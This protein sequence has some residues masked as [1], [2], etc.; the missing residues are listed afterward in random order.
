MNYLFNKQR[1]LVEKPS[2]NTMIILFFAL[3]FAGCVK[4]DE[5]ISPQEGTIY[6]PQAYQDRAT[7]TVYKIDS[8]QSITFGATYSGFKSAPSDITVE[9]QVDTSLIAAYNALN[10]YLGYTYYA[11]P[12]SA[13]T[14]SATKAVIP[15]GKTSSEPLEI[16]IQG[17]K[18]SFGKHY[19]L[20]IKLVNTASAK[21]DSSLS[22]AYFKLDTLLTRSRDLTSLGTLTVSDE[23]SGGADAG[24]GS[25]KL[26]DNDY[27]TKF[28]SFDYNP[29]FWVQLHLSSAEKLN[30][31]IITSGNDAPERDP[32]DWQF[33]GSDDG[34]NWTTLD[35]KTSES[36][37]ERLMTR[38]FDISSTQSYS[39]YRLYITANGG[40]NLI[41]ITE[42]RLLQ[43]Y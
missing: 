10:A 1:K 40:S 33:Q 12:D 2:F 8:V 5:L 29:N 41:Q 14:L 6:M 23:N 9:F 20:P 19:L 18:L 39:Y 43:Y 26:V 21:V 31:Y 36:F 38:R 35:T 16:Q 22:V 15:A 11:L 7:M 27:N 3:V 34:V 32:K 42:W 4:N 37:P 13:Y 24:E 25:K 17:S 28:L 30:A